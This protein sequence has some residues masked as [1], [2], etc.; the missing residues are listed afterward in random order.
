MTSFGKKKISIS[1]VNSSLENNVLNRQSG[2]VP[3][4]I[5][6]PVDRIL[7]PIPNHVYCR[8]ILQNSSR[9]KVFCYKWSVKAF[10]RFLITI[11]LLQAAHRCRQV[12]LPATAAFFNSFLHSFYSSLLFTTFSKFSVCCSYFLIFILTNKIRKIALSFRSKGN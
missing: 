3:N 10:A 11:S 5:W 9:S 7:Q 4:K 2:T 1:E 8:H 6:C 12:S